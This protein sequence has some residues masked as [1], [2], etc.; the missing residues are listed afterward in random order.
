MEFHVL[1]QLAF[2][3]HGVA[4]CKGNSTNRI[5]HSLVVQVR[6]RYQHA[7]PD[8]RHICSTPALIRRRRMRHHRRN[9][10]CHTTAGGSSGGSSCSCFCAAPAGS[11]GALGSC[12]GPA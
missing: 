1:V 7:L 4:D 6:Q 5:D 2:K 12:F 10:C 8:A 9:S 11:S 3:M